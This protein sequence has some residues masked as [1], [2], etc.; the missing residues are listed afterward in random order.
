MNGNSLSIEP[1]Y[2]AAASRCQPHSA[3]F[4]DWKLSLRQRREYHFRRMRNHRQQR[5]C[6]ASRS[7]LALLPIA[8]GFDGHAELCRELLLGQLRRR[9]RTM[10]VPASKGSANGIAGCTANSCPS[11]NSTIRPSAFSRKRRMPNPPFGMGI[12]GD[13]R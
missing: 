11:R 8:D 6:R 4:E 1:H 10:V 13:A 12:F 7:A 9:S 5:P 2:V 3:C